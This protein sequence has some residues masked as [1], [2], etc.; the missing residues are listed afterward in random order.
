M[1]SISFKF[2]KQILLSCLLPT[3]IILLSF[4]F[5]SPIIQ[6]STALINDSTYENPT[7]GIRMQY[8]SGW[9]VL[10]PSESF[11]TSAITYFVSPDN[12]SFV[13]IVIES[14]PREN[15]T[16]ENYTE[17]G[18]IYLNKYIPSFDNK[19]ILD[20][21]IKIGNATAK[22]LEFIVK[23]PMQNSFYRVM[24][25]V[26]LSGSKAYVLTYISPQTQYSR[27]LPVVQGMVKSFEIFVPEQVNSSSWQ[28]ILLVGGGFVL[29]LLVV[30][31]ISFVVI[32]KL[33]SHFKKS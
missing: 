4:C 22:Q 16:L 15:I 26:F 31:F 11:N 28:S 10:T 17:T 18:L 27:D 29:I 12:N 19:S 8:P 14:L 33:R 30:I 9:K 20:N 3:S 1:H 25:V 13:N 7:Y 21:S 32:K 24:E 23:D 6:R 2:Q 5:F